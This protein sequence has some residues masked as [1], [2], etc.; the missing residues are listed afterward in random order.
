L[1]KKAHFPPGFLGFPPPPAQRDFSRKNRA[2]PG[3]EQDILTVSNQDR[4]EP[5]QTKRHHV[6]SFEKPRQTFGTAPKGTAEGR[7]RDDFVLH[8][9]RFYALRCLASHYINPPVG[10]RF[11][12]RRGSLYENNIELNQT[13]KPSNQMRE[14]CLRKSWEICPRKSYQH[15]HETHTT[16]H[17]TTPQHTSKPKDTHTTNP[18]ANSAGGRVAVS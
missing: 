18:V 11:S 14:I 13:I 12:S 16:P 3:G 9:I 8:T 6:A 15:Q 2:P 1:K 4:R 5:L 10:A 17:H 7:D